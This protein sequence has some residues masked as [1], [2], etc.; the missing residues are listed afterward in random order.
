MDDQGWE[1]RRAILHHN[2][3]HHRFYHFLASAED[4]LVLYLMHPDTRRLPG[5]EKA[6]DAWPAFSQHVRQLFAQAPTLAIVDVDSW[7]ETKALSFRDRTADSQQANDATSSTIDAV[8][9]GR[10]AKRDSR[11][12]RALCDSTELLAAL[13]LAVDA[14]SITNQPMNK[15]EAMEEAQRFLE[16]CRRFDLA[17]SA[18]PTALRDSSAT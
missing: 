9:S 12:A 10:A 11:I 18:I 14:L 7:L 2:D 16:L 3:Y 13:D 8:V 15:W 5:I 6:I 1:R 4:A 17:F